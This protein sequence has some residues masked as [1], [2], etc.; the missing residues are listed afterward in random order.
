LYLIPSNACISAK[1]ELAMKKS[2]TYTQRASRIAYLEEKEHEFKFSLQN[3][4]EI[5]D[6]A[7]WLAKK[8]FEN[9]FTSGGS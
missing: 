4:E 6:A 2:Y 8:D 3:F 9:Q 1:G 7:A 5:N